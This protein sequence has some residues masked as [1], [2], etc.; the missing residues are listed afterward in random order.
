MQIFNP[1][2]VILLVVGTLS[3]AV[4]LVY[5]FFR[6]RFLDIIP[7]ALDALFNNARNFILILDNRKRITAINPAARQA[8]DL[9]EKDLIGAPP[10]GKLGFI[11]D[12]LRQH[13][14]GT[15]ID[16]VELQIKDEI[17]SF[18]PTIWNLRQRGNPVGWAVTLQDSTKHQ[19]IKKQ[20]LAAYDEMEKRVQARTAELTEANARLHR[21]IRQRQEAEA[22]RENVYRKTERIISAIQ[23]VIIGLDEAYRITFWNKIAEKTFDL[24]A[25]NVMN[26]PLNEIGPF[27]NWTVIYQ[28]LTKCRQTNKIEYVLE[29][30]GKFAGS[31]EK[32]LTFTINP[33]AEH[34]TDTFAFLLIGEDVTERKILEAQLTQSQKLESIGQLAA[35]IAH[36]INT[37]TQYVGDNNRF[38]QDSFR[39]INAY[40]SRSRQI[41]RDFNNGGLKPESIA[42]LES[43]A[44]KMDL[45]FLLTEIPTALKDAL[46]GVARVSKIVQAMRSFSHIGN[47]ELTD[48][49]INNAIE[50]TVTVARNEYKYVADMELDLNPDIPLVPCLPNE[51]NQVFLNL[52]INAAH[53]IGDVV[54]GTN[55]KGKITISTVSDNSTVTIKI[56][57]TG[58]GI[59]ESVRSKIFDPFFTTK[60]VG[61]GTGQGLAISHNVVVEKHHGLIHFETE[62]GKGT[63]FIVQL[64]LKR[65]E[66]EEVSH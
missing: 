47:D 17:R 61:K 46:D 16:V 21:E 60:E 40:I 58:T 54:K 41:M 55:S 23:T 1:W 15:E 2:T 7:N 5:G 45:D 25:E 28:G 3:A 11:N 26:R 13:Y 8:L 18:S 44:A 39:Q 29:T 62:V 37:P 49:D 32:F 33:I 4:A 35:G 22:A 31:A 53:A 30:S 9:F 14:E 64:P 34:D 63:T 59:P 66:T 50:N 43:M 48:I 19:N 57:D 42:E 20:L 10:K 65:S 38:V 36:E 52:I 51:I 56:S 6:N 27:F 12:L 24:S